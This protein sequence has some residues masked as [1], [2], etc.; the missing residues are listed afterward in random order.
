MSSGVKAAVRNSLKIDL[1]TGN[2]FRL[3][4]IQDL[5]L[6]SWLKNMYA[7]SSED[8]S[9]N[10]FVHR[11]NKYK[12]R[13]K[14]QSNTLLKGLYRG[15]TNG[16]HNVKT[17]PFLFFDIDVKN[18]KEKKENTH[19]LSIENN[20]RIFDELKK[21]SVL[22]WRSNSGNGIAG[23]LYVPQIVEFTNND[24][25]KHKKVG[26][27]ITDF[28]SKYLH[29]KTG[30]APV[31]FDEA[32]SKF[33]QVRHLAEQGE[34]RELNPKA[35]AFHYSITEIEQKTKCNVPIYYNANYTA[36][37]GSVIE[38]FNN[39]N[40]ILDV[41]Q[42]A[43]FKEI[44]RNG[45]EIRVKHRL[46]T[47]KTSG[48]IATDQN[49][50]FNYSGS[51]DN[52]GSFKPADIVCKHDFE[53]D[54]TKFYR[55]LYK[56]GYKDKSPSKDEIKAISEDLK[57][58]PQTPKI[59]YEYCYNLQT[60][61]DK[62]KEQFIKDTC[63]N[64][65]DKKYF[66]EYL[67]YSDYSIHYRNT[68][69]IKQYVSEAIPKILNFADQYKKVI[70]RAETGT[71]KT[72]AVINEIHKYRTNARLMILAPL[73]LI[74]EQ[75]AKA[76]TDKG[77]YLTGKSTQ[78]DREKALESKLVFATYEQ[79]TKYLQDSNNFDFVIVD[80][81]HELITAN[82]YKYE[83]I[84]DLS[85][86]FKDKKII[87]LTATPLQIFNKV[88]YEFLNVKKQSQKATPVEI[89]YS[90]INPFNLAL[91]HLIDVEGKT[92]LRINSIDTLKDLKK[93][94]IRA[95]KYQ[96]DEIVILYSTKDIKNGKYYNYLA[97][98]ERFTDN[99]KLVLATAIIDEGINIRQDDFTDAVFIETSYTP[100]P[101]AI[102]QFFAR[103]RTI[104]P[105]RKNYLYLRERNDQTATKYKPL[106][107]F[108]PTKE[109]LILDKNNELFNYS[110]YGD[111]FNNDRFYYSSGNINIYYLAYHV[112][113]ILFLTMNSDQFRYFLAAN[114]NLTFTINDDFVIKSNLQRDT[115]HKDRLK[116]EIAK[117]WK[118]YKNSV[119]NTVY[120]H[121][122]D[123]KLKNRLTLSQ[124]AKNDK[125]T[126]L[127]LN[128]LKQFE[129]LIKKSL[130]LIDLG[131]KQ[132]DKILISRKINLKDKLGDNYPDKEDTTLISESNF[133]K[134]VTLLELGRMI[135]N[136]KNETDKKNRRKFLNFVDNA[137]EQKEMSRKQL[138]KLLR[139]HRVYNSRA[140]SLDMLKHVFDSLNVSFVYDDLHTGVIK[141]SYPKKNEE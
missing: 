97:D 62:V 9:L 33:R 135:Y 17:A 105:Q 55:H 101:E 8:I 6:F 18:N 39:D 68:L 98:K 116:Y 51:Y 112:T 113:K 111:L 133:K 102:K 99:T 115:K 123:K 63:K 67:K 50:Y 74:V 48:V 4:E 84:R 38:Q 52:R 59:I 5:K 127:V 100:R 86:C 121:T 110:S 107:D 28:V 3:D 136:P 80:E 64:E 24:R 139:K 85:E 31:Q 137:I 130:K 49:T 108:E 44:S 87:G 19:L 61:P 141:I 35:L 57:S 10:E 27:A 34:K 134:G 73:T 37:Y 42:K 11:L 124:A 83:V 79:G 69:N 30:I 117:A 29:E 47:S 140:F 75:Q 90:N 45:N 71:G 23:V 58:K 16:I 13:P 12:K 65:K 114:Y 131:E 109:A 70:V 22:V 60:A 76:N 20:K 41:C 78:E 129:S 92:I 126:A 93:H 95:G 40:N 94:L 77:V 125:I 14:N 81:I 1:S 89:R 106:K 104:T 53:G 46:T 54:Y 91:S 103:F 43:G 56:K 32:Q 36:P 120:Y 138:Y 26:E 88:G 72:H 21:I 122:Q 118:Q 25:S 7:K 82:S 66:F 2:D 15:G 132:P 119:Q 128:H 96:A